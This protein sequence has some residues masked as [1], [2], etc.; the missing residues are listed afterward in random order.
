[1]DYSASIGE[2][3]LPRAPI[4]SLSSPD[5]NLNDRK[6]LTYTSPPLDEDVTVIGSPVVT[7]F[8]SS[9]SS[10]GNFYV[11]LEEIDNNGKSF[12]ITNGCLRAS[13]RKESEPSFD[14]MDLPYHRHF[15]KDI[16]PIPQGQSVELRF[17]LLPVSNI[18]NKG[19]RI[20]VSIS[21]A[22]D[23]WDEII[24]E[25]PVPE[26]TIYRNSQLASKIALPVLG[27]GSL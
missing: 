20:R 13:H 22:N 6:G 7:F 4:Q 1:M 11:Y 2:I 18:F 8:V 19:H 12:L 23:K 27:S 10:D 16:I 17:D 3:H 26:V 25:K 21:C 24:E 5:M 15:E 14:N 9:N